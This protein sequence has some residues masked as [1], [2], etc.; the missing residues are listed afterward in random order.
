MNVSSS[1]KFLL[2]IRI[3]AKHENNM[4]GT[5]AKLTPPAAASLRELDVKKIRKCKSRILGLVI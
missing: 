4:I 3:R 5:G 2:L 1:A